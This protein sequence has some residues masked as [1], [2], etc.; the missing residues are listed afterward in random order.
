MYTVIAGGGQVGRGLARRLSERRHD[1]VVIE[2]DREACEALAARLGVVTVHGSATDIDVLHDAGIEKAEV[3][4]AAMPMDGDNLSFCLLAREAGVPQIMVR[5][6]DARYAEAYRLAGATCT[7]SMPSLF[8]RRLLIEIEQPE[9]EQ[10]AT[11]GGGKAG[12]VV[13]TIPE[14]SVA[15]GATV[16]EIAGRSEFPE[17]CVVAGIFR[18]ATDEFIFPRGNAQVLAGDRVFLAADSENVTQAAAFLRRV[19]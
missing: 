18:P 5:M 8:V 3:A 16:Q 7:V 11:Y 15:A 19:R 1:V 6:R 10:I 12:I 9:L 2:R 13:V 17:K 14:K 4:V